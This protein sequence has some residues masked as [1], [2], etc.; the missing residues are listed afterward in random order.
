MIARL[1]TCTTVV[2]IARVADVD[3]DALGGRVRLIGLDVLPQA[4]DTSSSRDEQQLAPARRARPPAP[5]RRSGLLDLRDSGSRTRWPTP[6]WLV[7]DE[8]DTLQCSLSIPF[9][10]VQVRLTRRSRLVTSSH[11]RHIPVRFVNPVR[12]RILPSG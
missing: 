3:V 6:A 2:G 5:R 12:A 9:G 4:P 8:L 7:H 10:F 1:R 11:R